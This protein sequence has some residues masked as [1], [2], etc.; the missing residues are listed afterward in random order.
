VLAD[1][2]AMTHLG[3]IVAA[4]GATAIVLGGMIGWV[5]LDLNAQKRKLKRIE[6]DGGRRSRVLG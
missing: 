4:Y 3:Y 5:L 6:A 1:E 2:A